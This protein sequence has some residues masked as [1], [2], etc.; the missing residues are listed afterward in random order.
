[1]CKDVT[2]V[3]GTEAEKTIT[4][5]NKTYTLVEDG[6]GTNFYKLVDENAADSS[7][8]YQGM[9]CSILMSDAS[10]QDLKSGL[11]ISVYDGDIEKVIIKIPTLT[12]IND[13]TAEPYN[14]RSVI[15][16]SLTPYFNELV[17]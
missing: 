5:K 1:M 14:D 7:V 17:G 16:I 13:E 4:V 12:K 11:N 15:S 6:E 3:V 10:G 2:I 9:M 8:L